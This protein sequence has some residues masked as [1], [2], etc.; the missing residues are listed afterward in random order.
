MKI[1]D[2]IPYTI[3]IVIALFMSLAPLNGDPHL[4]EKWRMLVSSTLSKPIDIFDLVL[5]STPLIILA[6]KI[7]RTISLKIKTN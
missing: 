2:K 4:V 7:I 1:L 3:I 5:H 6:L